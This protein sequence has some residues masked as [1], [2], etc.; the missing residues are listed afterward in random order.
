MANAPVFT[1]EADLYSDDD[2]SSSLSDLD[3]G[4][5]TG[6]IPETVNKI[7]AVADGD[8]EAETERLEVSPN[9]PV[10]QEN[11]LVNSL[12]MGQKLDGYPNG[13]SGAEDVEAERFSDSVVSSPRSSDEESLSEG[14]S[15]HNAELEEMTFDE[16]EAPQV[17]AGIKR[18]RTSED[19]RSDTDEDGE[20]RA[21]RK[22]TGSIRSDLEPEPS[23]SEDEGSSVAN[24]SREGSQDVM[25]MADDHEDELVVGAN[26]DERLTETNE[27]VELL[28]SAKRGRQSSSHMRVSQHED[29]EEP[30]ISQA[31]EEQ[32]EVA[33][34]SDEEELAENDDIED[35]EAA[36]RSE[37]ER[38]PIDTSDVMP[39]ID[40][41]TDAKRTAAMDAL[42]ALEKRFATLRDRLA[43]PMLKTPSRANDNRLYDERIASIN[44]ELAQ[45]SGPHPTHPELLRQVQVV[46][47][48]RD[49]KFDIEQKLLVFKIGA[50]KRKS[51]AERAQI[52]SAYFQTVRDVREKHLERASEYFYRIQRDRFKTDESVPSFSI[53]FPTRRSQQITQQTAYN[54]EVSILSGVAKYIGFPA[55]PDLANASSGEL[56]EDLEKMGVSV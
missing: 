23:A 2:R 41:D 56:D 54:K 55:A 3:E 43:T 28:A 22:R 50:L 49:E 8:S 20:K 21:R 32:V 13:R 7:M 52:H 17:S 16:P 18:K 39:G 4:V 27:A 36:V 40:K 15:D 14:I 6:T 25:D 1:A 48:H 42:L 37:E 53:P 12:P 46:Q 29:S 51:I 5:E 47:Q 44:H 34:G 26:E 10:K 24:L 11:I 38:E 35:A 45:L 33:E 30:V 31:E 19:N 9:K